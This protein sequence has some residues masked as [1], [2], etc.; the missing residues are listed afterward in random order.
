MAKGAYIGVGYATYPDSI[1]A[2]PV[3]TVVKIKENGSQVD[4]IIVHQG[5]PD[6]SLYDPS[7]D[8]TW[9]LR[10]NVYSKGQYHTS[11]DDSL[12]Y[13]KAYVHTYL[14][15]TFLSAVDSDIRAVIKDVKIPYSP[16]RSVLNSGANGL[17]TKAFLLGGYE[18]N[19]KDDSLHKDGAVLEYFK[20]SPV[21]K[22]ACDSVWWLRTNY[23]TNPPFINYVAADGT[24][25][26]AQTGC[27]ATNY[28]IRPAFILPSTLFADGNVVTSQQAEAVING[29]AHKIKKGYIGVSGVA[30][31]IKKAYI[32]IGG[33]A[34]PCWS[35]GELAYYGTITPLNA[36]TDY[37]CATS[38]EAYA[39]FAGM[40][41]TSTAYDKSLTKHSPTEVFPSTNG[42][43]TSI[44]NYALFGYGLS[45]S[46]SYQI[47][48]VVAYDKSLTRTAKS[49]KVARSELAATTIGNHALFG[50][51]KTRSSYSNAVDAFDASLTCTA[52]TVFSTTKAKYAATTVG[53]YA[54]FGGGAH[55]SSGS[56]I[57]DV[58]AYDTS[59]TRSTATEL[60][61]AR[62]DLT[63]TTAGNHALF[64]SGINGITAITAVEAYDTSLTKK[65]VTALSNGGQWKVATS[66]NGFALFAGNLGV[67]N[68]HLVDAYDESLTKVPVGNL[69]VGRMRMGA[70]SI[71]NFALFGGGNDGDGNYT[72]YSD[73]VEAFTVA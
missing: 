65:S 29:K 54:L 68:G 62:Q 52:A 71:G 32:G 70:T 40:G 26:N 60:S 20:D 46:N 45:T 10:K 6:T 11:Q 8:G 14:N 53:N 49:G 73:V 38:N 36:K 63:A 34:R 30:R 64:G 12:N 1:G 7:C 3:G 28:G 61:Y 55:S 37:L 57:A 16:S 5:N 48:T 42:V 47:Q 19:A 23:W 9:V 33:V 17:Q 41:V 43:A 31:K 67:N 13:A 72:T 25:I 58:V 56:A 69:S 35:G 59:L 15:S 27:T 44:G 39:V 22:R 51:G 21:T 50:G 18:V 66:L 24:K 2:L 4:Y